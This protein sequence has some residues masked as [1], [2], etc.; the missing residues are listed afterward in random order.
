MQE[1]L[2]RKETG[3]S[4]E[5]LQR[6]ARG[7]KKKMKI[8]HFK[9]NQKNAWAFFYHMD[10]C[11]DELCKISSPMG[12]LKLIAQIGNSGFGLLQIP[13]M[14]LYGHPITV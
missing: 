9:K 2:A 3:N 8:I 6:S 7:K 4:G 12:K 14:H 5:K 13:K 10:Y 1:D 11:K